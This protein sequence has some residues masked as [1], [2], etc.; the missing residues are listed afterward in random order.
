MIIFFYSYLIQAIVEFSVDSS[1]AFEFF[2]DF[3]FEKWQSASD[4]VYLLELGVN[5]K[6][7]FPEN[8]NLTKCF[9]NLNK[10]T[11]DISGIVV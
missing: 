1:D 7:D 2:T 5:G 9:L 3:C 10:E 4:S 11:E 6:F 8:S